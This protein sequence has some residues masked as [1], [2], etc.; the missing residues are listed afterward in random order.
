LTRGNDFAL[1][2]RVRR[3][4]LDHSG[5]RSPVTKALFAGP[6]GF[7]QLR[8]I[9]ARRNWRPEDLLLELA[10]GAE[11]EVGA[12]IIPIL[13]RRTISQDF[14]VFGDDSLSGTYGCVNEDLVDLICDSCRVCRT[15]LPTAAEIR[16]EKLESVRDL[17]SLV[18]RLRAENE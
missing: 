10:N 17:I 1:I 14:P 9:A 7:L 8:L 15:R 11:Q 18:A 12:K 2:L 4:M 3:R 6:T 16:R 5:N 13:Q